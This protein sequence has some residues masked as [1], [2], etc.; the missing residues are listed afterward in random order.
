MELPGPGSIWFASDFEFLAPVH[1]GDDVEVTVR[2]TRVSVATSVVFLDVTAR[3]L[4]DTQVLR[5]RAKVRLCSP[6][7]Q[8]D[9]TIPDSEKSVLVTGASRGLGRSIAMSLAARETARIFDEAMGAFGRVDVVV[10]NAT[11]PIVPKPYAEI[12][13]N[14]FV[15]SSRR[16]WSGW[17]SSCCA[18]RRR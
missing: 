16:M 6:M 11:P 2:V 13:S 18:T 5:G 8:R 9:C 12:A 7:A 3:R 10:H 17:T 1:T 15:S 4:P 14:D